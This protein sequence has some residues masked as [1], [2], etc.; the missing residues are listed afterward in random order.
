[1]SESVNK[2]RI[3]KV[4]VKKFDDGNVSVSFK[5]AGDQRFFRCGK[6]RNK[7]VVE[8][9]NVIKFNYDEVSEDA[10]K[11]I[12]KPSLVTGGGGEDE[13]ASKPAG[14]PSGGGFGSHDSNIQYQSSR[15]D[16]LVFVELIVAQGAIKLPA[17]ESAKLEVLE[18][19]LDRYTSVF[20][21]DIGTKGA[22]ARTAPKAKPEADDDDAEEPADDNDD[23][24]E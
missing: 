10:A 16:A 1:M 14:K 17:K 21:A 9:G 20:Y 23:D 19:L 24:N 12:G 22:I 15:K 2:A 13:G 8:E 4:Y 18:G 7:G 3:T 11:V 5:I 6:F